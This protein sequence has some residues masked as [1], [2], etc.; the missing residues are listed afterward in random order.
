MNILASSENNQS[1]YSVADF[2]VRFTTL[3]ER[4]V[5][6]QEKNANVSSH[7]N[8]VKCFHFKILMMCRSIV[9]PAATRL[10]ISPAVGR[11]N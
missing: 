2:F 8:G 6:L 11:I 7:R 5:S 9:S 4:N 3:S 1:F 10:A